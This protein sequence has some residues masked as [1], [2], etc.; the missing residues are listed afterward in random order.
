MKNIL[1]A[2]KQVSSQHPSILFEFEKLYDN[3]LKEEKNGFI[4]I[5]TNSFYPN[6]IICKYSQKCV[7]KQQWNIF[8]LMARGLILDIKNK[9]VIARTMPKFFNYGE[10]EHNLVFKED[11][12]VTEKYDGSCVTIFYFNDQWMVST[13]G[14]FNSDQSKWAKDYLYN[15]IAINKLDT[16]VTYMAEVIY[17]A[18][19]I[20]VS[21]YYEGLVLLTAFKENGYEYSCDEINVMSVCLH[22]HPPKIYNFNNIDKIIETSKKLDLSSEG[23][24]LRFFN[25]VR[26]K[27]KGDEYIRV[28]HLLNSVTPLFIWETIK[29]KGDVEAIRKELPEE[30][31]EEFDNI[32]NI[33]DKQ[34][35]GL[36]DDIR[37]VTN[38]VKNKSNKEI[39][40]LIQDHSEYFNYAKFPESVRYIF[41]KRNGRF[42]EDYLRINSHIR[43]RVFDIIRPKNNVI[44]E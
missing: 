10:I 13:L 4:N 43:N 34:L 5:N 3:L 8:T 40:L 24:V 23:F 38:E 25:G 16:T 22:F 7:Y 44:N 37:F 39:G 33:I 30:L 6:L 31:V 17:K 27:I 2:I 35:N 42:D 1:E 28:H 32:N 15:N 21:Y 41:S 9:K 29:N 19:K 12:T 20:V 14:S 36:L 11:F 18:N 26:I